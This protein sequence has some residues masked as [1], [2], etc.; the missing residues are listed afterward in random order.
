MSVAASLAD[1]EVA[2]DMLH[3]E[4]LS[5]QPLDTAHWDAVGQS[6]ERV[7]GR[8]DQLAAAAGDDAA[9]NAAAT[10]AAS[11]RRYRFAIEAQR[12]VR[13]SP[14]A[15]TADQLAGAD[16]ARRTSASDLDSGINALRSELS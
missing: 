13:S 5:D 12:L 1:A 16:A 6:V 14:T 2:R 7:A 3:G 10:V 8:F 4:A 11:L 9:R 15:P